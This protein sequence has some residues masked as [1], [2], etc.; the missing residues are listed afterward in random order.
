MSS[1]GGILTLREVAPQRELASSVHITR[2]SGGIGQMAIL[3]CQPVAC[4]ARKCRGGV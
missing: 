2:L 4:T 3:N 1:S